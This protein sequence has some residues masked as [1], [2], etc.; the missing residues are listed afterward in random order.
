M[1][2]HASSG[3]RTL[4]CQALV[5][6]WYMYYQLYDKYETCYVQNLGILVPH[7]SSGF[8]RGGSDQA[9]CRARCSLP[10]SSG[11]SPAVGK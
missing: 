4:L 2:G 7:Y 1:Y 5:I 10:N 3:L 9:A 11:Q 8:W 6:H